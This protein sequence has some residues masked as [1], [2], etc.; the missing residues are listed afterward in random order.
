M[1]RWEDRDMSLVSP[2]LRGQIEAYVQHG[3]PPGPFWTA[4]LS[5]QM[6]ELFHHLV[7]DVAVDAHLIDT[8][9][10]AIITFRDRFVPREAWG[11]RPAVE[12]WI[13]RG[14]LNGWPE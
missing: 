12:R 8:Q 2:R 10:P 3:V 1:P 7:D 11:T 9:L 13:E 6:R 4:L 14:G 5:G